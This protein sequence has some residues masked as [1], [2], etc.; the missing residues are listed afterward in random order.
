M[1]RLTIYI[2]VAICFFG[3]SCGE[4]NK[5]VNEPINEKLA[6]SAKEGITYNNHFY[7]VIT[8][9][10]VL[11]YKQYNEI[12]VEASFFLQRGDVVELKQGLNKDGFYL[13]NIPDSSSAFYLK[14]LP[15]FDQI[16][17]GMRFPVVG[18]I[19]SEGVYAKVYNEDLKSYS[20]FE[21]LE[22]GTT[23]FFV[24]KK[25]VAYINY[26]SKKSN[27]PITAFLGGTDT[28]LHIIQKEDHISIL[29]KYKTRVK[30]LFN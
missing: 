17:E 1:K 16:I 20:K 3:V 15:G 13:I 23:Y 8:D 5:T 22:V 18:I 28:Q 4:E 25:D 6:L 11:V 19:K 29:K 9:S 21:D 14:I 24:I 2:I 10:N 12:Y 30:E 26:W 7:T 27:K